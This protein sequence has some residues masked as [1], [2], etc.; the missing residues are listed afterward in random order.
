MKVCCHRLKYL[1]MDEISTVHCTG[2]PE[3]NQMVL[4]NLNQSSFFY[5]LG[6]KLWSY[7]HNIRFCRHSFR[8]DSIHSFDL[9]NDF[10]SMLYFVSF[11]MQ[12]EKEEKKETC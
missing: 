11:W 2:M 7:I 3:A 9:S 1:E 4:N 10:G 8:M 6:I 12:K 5:I